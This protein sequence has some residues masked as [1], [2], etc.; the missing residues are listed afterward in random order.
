MR[1][2]GRASVALFLLAMSVLII[3]IALTRVFSF[4]SWYHFAYL[5]I[6][7]ALLGFGAAGS[8]LT[9]SPRFAGKEIDNRVVGRYALAFSLATVIGF[10]TATKVRFYPMDAYMYG[11]Y[12]NVYSLLLLYSTSSLEPS[13]SLR[14][15]A[16]ATSF[17]EPERPS[18][19]FTSQICWARE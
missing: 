15:F 1:D 18:T 13:F 10:F 17:P 14:G 4:M 16:S 5:I 8:F 2:S 7:L 11:D 3:E 9:V 6:S 19:G 12:S